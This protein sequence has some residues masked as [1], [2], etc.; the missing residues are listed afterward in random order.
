MG[1]GYLEK[2]NDEGK[3]EV[4]RRQAKYGSKI[5]GAQYGG[6]QTDRGFV[7]Q[8][9]RPDVPTLT[10][11][12]PTQ[13]G[14]IDTVPAYT[15]D[16]TSPK[17]GDFEI[18]ARDLLEILEGNRQDA[19]VP[20]GRSKSG[21]TIG[22]G[23]DVG[24]HSVKDL[25]KMGFDSNIINKLS[26][27]TMKKGQAAK[28]FL[29]SNPLSFNDEEIENINKIVLRDKYKKFEK[30]YP[31]YAQVKDVGK[32][33]VMF[34]A[35]FGGGL[36]RYKTFQKEFKKAQNMESALRKGLINI[37]PKGAPEYNRA[38]KALNWFQEYGMELMPIPKSKPIQ[39]PSATR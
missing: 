5:Q 21:A 39:N 28:S 1:K 20:K 30:F 6:I 13:Q 29:K 34:S 14:F 7:Q 36:Q 8:F 37:I 32:R 10:A 3:P 26:P 15:S 12:Q 35:Y 18:K 31:E 9:V 17:L 27:Y 22:I 24:Q 25:Q 16:T 38:K 2:L 4:S 11:P 23:F 19:Y 33:A